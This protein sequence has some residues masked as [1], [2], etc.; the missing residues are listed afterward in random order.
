MYDAT[1]DANHA[2]VREKTA[3][4]EIA[5]FTGRADYDPENKPAIDAVFLRRLL[6]GLEGDGHVLMPGVRMRGA[7]VEGRLDLADCSGSGGEGIPAL[8]LEACDLPD[9][10][11]LSGARVARLS[12]ADSRFRELRG[13]GLKID[14]DFD[15][16]RA[17]PLAVADGQASAHINLREARI[18]GG[19]SGGGARLAAP[20]ELHPLAPRKTSALELVFA[21]IAGG[22]L[23]TPDF[24]AVGEVRLLGAR[25]GGNLN[26]E[27]SR[28]ESTDATALNASNAQIGGAALFRNGFAAKGE[29]R[30][31]AARIVGALDC[32]GGHFANPGGD[33]LTAAG[34]EIAGAVFL[35][36]GFTSSGVVSL[37]RAKIDALDISKASLANEGGYALLLGSARVE[38]RFYAQDNKIQGAVSLTGA[39]IGRLVDDPDTAWVGAS[40]IGLNELTY[41][42][43]AA[44]HGARR[45]QWKARTAWLKRNTARRPARVAIFSNQP[46]NEC[47][48][49]FERAGLHEDARRIAH[50]EEREANRHRPVWL[51][52]FFW[53]FADLPFGYG[54]SLWRTTLT[55]LALW[56]AGWI[57]TETMLVRGAL[58]DSQPAD[59]RPHACESVTPPLYALD[60]AIPVLDLAQERE[61]EP[62]RA[63]RANLGAGIPTPFGPFLEEV[64]AWRWAKTLYALIGAVVIGF[65][66][67]VY[68]GVF[69]PKAQA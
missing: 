34:A 9:A 22:V 14:A 60:T 4:G 63:P 12:I 68:S 49:A 27:H 3:L 31:L 48:A 28:L 7:R 69:K 55:C 52:P 15:F 2:F 16:R 46:W 20:D 39:H 59:G 51:R 61:C 50:E 45:P 13:I 43:L 32:A 67:L 65:A 56:G 23:L 36:D 26:C 17:V 6:L 18:S 19:V 29:V 64:A 30:L 5:D 42:Q 38:G 40:A 35:R 53:L 47:A 24:S 8:A 1:L 21:E 57:G 44:P 37:V 33:A 10:I 54:L 66:I 25:I 41:A 11:D 62:G 58:I